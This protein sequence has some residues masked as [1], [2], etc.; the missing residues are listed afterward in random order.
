LLGEKAAEGTGGDGMD[1][2][3]VGLEAGA[4]R[5]LDETFEGK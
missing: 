5:P 1:G 4:A 2:N 3:D